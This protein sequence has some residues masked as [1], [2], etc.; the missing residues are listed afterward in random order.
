[1]CCMWLAGNAGPKNRKKIPFA[2]RRTTLWSY[3]FATK[4]C[5]DNQNKLVKQQLSSPHASQY[6]EL[7]PTSG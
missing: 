5:I 1:M 6:G 4:A 7:R 3:I 2:Y